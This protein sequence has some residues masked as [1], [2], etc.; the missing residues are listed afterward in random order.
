MRH[1]LVWEKSPLL[2]LS[3]IQLPNKQKIEFFYGSEVSHS[4]LK[5]RA[6]HT[7]F[8]LLGL[9]GE[10]LEGRKIVVT[11]ASISVGHL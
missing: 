5:A 2:S 7:G 3:E 6:E 9:V 4:N 1:H 10:H 11:L 8:L